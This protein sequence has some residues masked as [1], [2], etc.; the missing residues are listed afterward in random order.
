MLLVVQDDK[1]NTRHMFQVLEKEQIT[2]RKRVKKYVTDKQGNF[3]ND[4]HGD[5]VWKWEFVP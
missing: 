3:I 4:E 5:P 2:V 1:F